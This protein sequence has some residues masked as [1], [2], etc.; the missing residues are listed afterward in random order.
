MLRWRPTPNPVLIHSP[1]HQGSK[2]QVELF[3]NDRQ[4][5]H[6]GLFGP[7]SSR[8][9]AV[10]IMPWLALCCLKSRALLLLHP[11]QDLTHTHLCV[12]DFIRPCPTQ[13]T[14]T[15]RGGLHQ[16]PPRAPTPD[17]SLAS[18][19][20]PRKRSFPIRSFGQG[21]TPG[22]QQTRFALDDLDSAAARN[23]AHQ[24]RRAKGNRDLLQ[25]IEGIAEVNW[26]KRAPCSNRAGLDL[27]L[28]F[29][30]N[31]LLPADDRQC[32]ARY[33]ESGEGYSDPA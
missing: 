25:T 10:K 4:L 22:T 20:V 7:L 11:I 8:R 17:L 6:Q 13:H 21:A 28:L 23:P 26:R 5:W 14:M 29:L 2:H 31:R 24:P 32:S 15:S 33:K 1:S 3:C 16:P 30:P 19:P 12:C 27:V 9:R 18:R